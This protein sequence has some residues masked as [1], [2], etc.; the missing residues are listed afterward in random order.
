MIHLFLFSFSFSRFPFMIAG[1]F[2][3]HL[4]HVFLSC[5]PLCDKK[6]PVV[7]ITVLL[8]TLA[9]HSDKL[10][11]TISRGAWTVCLLLV[12]VRANGTQGCMTTGRP[13]DSHPSDGSPG[14][15]TGD[16]VF[17]WPGCRGVG[18]WSSA[19]RGNSASDRTV[20]FDWLV[21]LDLG[22]G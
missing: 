2:T 1:T 6:H 8:N 5:V 15:R 19:D 16:P 12:Q 17:A 13:T 11:A 20:P 9:R 4:P 21:D 14:A 10:E 3:R 22:S 7:V 18:D